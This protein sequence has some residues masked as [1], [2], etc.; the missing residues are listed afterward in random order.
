MSFSKLSDCNSNDS[1]HEYNCTKIKDVVCPP[2]SHCNDNCKY[3]YCDAK[4]SE[5]LK[6][7]EYTCIEQE[8]NNNS[9]F[10]FLLIPIIIIII[11][12]IV[13]CFCTRNIKNPK[14]YLEQ[15]YDKLNTQEVTKITLPQISISD[16][17]HLQQQQP[18]QMVQVF[19]QFQTIQNA[20]VQ[21]TPMP[22]IPEMLL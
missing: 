8:P 15:Q 22:V 2:F 19:P 6:C 16:Q 10:L 18:I 17:L 14:Q 1:H 11:F 7:D 12:T 21:I 13:I 5:L 4:Y 9:V 20:Q 3:G